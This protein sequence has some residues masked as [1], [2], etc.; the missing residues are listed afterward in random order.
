M[1]V[2]ARPSPNFDARTLPVSMLV[3]HYTDMA[4]CQAALE[5][6]CDE[7]AKVSAH[8]LIDRQGQ[9]YQLVEEDQRAWHAGLAHWN[10]IDDVNSASLGIELD[11]PGVARDGTLPAFPAAQMDALIELAGAMVQ[12][13]KIPPGNVLGHSDVAPTRK[14]DPGAAFDWQ[15]LAAHGIGLWPKGV[16]VQPVPTLERG[17]SGSAVNSLQQALKAF[18][19]Q[20]TADGFFGA[21]T[22]AVVTAFQR[23]YRPRQVDGMADAETQTLAYTLCRDAKIAAARL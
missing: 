5:R 4:D 13:H 6:L 21:Q 17:R 19:Y 20:L 3:I 8:Y 18:G 22:E 23:H 1:T 9:V 15:M 11:Y 12:R 10:G 7:A 14:R 2:I 16:V